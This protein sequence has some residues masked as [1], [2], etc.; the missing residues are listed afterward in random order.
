L[1][2]GEAQTLVAGS[3]LP[4]Q[5]SA[6]VVQAAAACLHDAVMRGSPSLAKPPSV[7][8]PAVSLL[9]SLPQPVKTTV[10]RTVGTR[11]ESAARESLF[12]GI[13]F[14]TKDDPSNLISL[15]E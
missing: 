6:L 15:T 4:V 12:M 10:A 1:P 14:E 2:S 11:M 5:Q 9:D 13:T 3:Q 7:P 8:A